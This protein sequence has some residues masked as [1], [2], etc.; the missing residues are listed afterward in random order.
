MLTD[1]KIK[2]SNFIKKHK[3]KIILLF[4]VWLIII[5]IN[6]YIGNLEEQPEIKTSYKPHESVMETGTEVPEKLQD[7]FEEI[8]NKYMEY[9]NQKNY[10]EAYKL[11]DETCKEEFF[12]DIETFKQ[13]VDTKFDTKK[14]YS[15]QNYSNVGNIYVYRIR[16]FDDILATGMTGQ[17]DFTYQEE[18]VSVYNDDGNLSLGIGSFI[19][20]E[21]LNET[22][23]DNDIKITVEKRIITYDT[24][25]YYVKVSNRGDNVAVISNYKTSGEIVLDIGDETRDNKSRILP[26]IVNPGGEM[27]IGLTFTKFFD[28]P[29]GDKKL[30]FNSIRIFENHTGAETDE[31]A[32]RAF[33]VEI[34]V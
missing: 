21:T 30:I 27:S 18:L 31:Q 12:P 20:K 33:A 19:G 14:A 1:I 5:F 6:N 11:I 24:E 9:C 8:L 25:V 22:Y 16:R 32:I 15:I 4:I 34:D 3:S 29:Q 26:I 10:E 7:P 28:E 13:Y 2:F 17:E 23:E